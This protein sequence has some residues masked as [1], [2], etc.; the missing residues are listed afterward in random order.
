[1][2]LS[3]S[4][5]RRSPLGFWLVAALLAFVTG[6]T[7]ARIVGRAEAAAAE[8]GSRR[9]VIVARHDVDAGARLSA[10]DLSSRVMPAA[11]VPAGAVDDASAPPVGRVVV[12]PLVRGQVVVDRQLAPHGLSPA[13]ALVPAGT[14]AI[15]LP[16]GGLAPPL[17]R[18]DV[19]DVYA[20][21][22]DGEEP[23]T[24]AVARAVTVVAVNAD[25]GSVTV[26]V[27]DANVDRV[28]FAVTTGEVTI[29]LA[30]GER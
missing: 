25:D 11:F 26:A 19:V 9:T 28:A 7:V 17:R 5:L 12:V 1:V 30:G 8:Y 15:A 3:P 14:R 21:F 27:D 6:T 10:G 20:T 2:R 22:D 24:F 13:A 18:G 4:R 29:V 16:T 23:P